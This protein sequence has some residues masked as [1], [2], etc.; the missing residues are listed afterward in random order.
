MYLS[1]V[2]FGLFVRKETEFYIQSKSTKMIKVGPPWNKS[3]WASY[4]HLFALLDSYILEA[5]LIHL[6]SIIWQT[7]YIWN[8][9]RREVKKKTGAK[10][11]Q[12]GKFQVWPKIFTFGQLARVTNILVK[13]VEFSKV[14]TGPNFGLSLQVCNFRALT[15]FGQFDHCW[16]SYVLTRFG[17]DLEKGWTWHFGGSYWVLVLGLGYLILI[18]LCKKDCW[19]FPL[20][21]FALALSLILGV[22]YLFVFFIFLHICIITWWRR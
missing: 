12:E 1:Q 8:Q 19:V 2:L 7:R 21:G 9:W 13:R 3:A 4:S 10:S 16:L 17:G 6:K 5:S 15:R 14:A 18:W 22:L 11:K 20:W